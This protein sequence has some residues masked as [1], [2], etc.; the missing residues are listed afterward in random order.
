M[1]NGIPDFVL[2][3]GKDLVKHTPGTVRALYSPV[4]DFT[5]RWEITLVGPKEHPIVVAEYVADPD[6]KDYHRI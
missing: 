5:N 1:A 2:K 3:V 4:E 6:F